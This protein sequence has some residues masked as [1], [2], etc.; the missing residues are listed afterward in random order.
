MGYFCLQIVGILEQAAI[1]TVFDRDLESPEIPRT[2]DVHHEGNQED[3]QRLG[4]STQNPA[5]EFAYIKQILR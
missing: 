1:C 4:N 3:L 5:I 2:P